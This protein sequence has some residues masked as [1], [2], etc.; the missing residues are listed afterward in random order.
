MMINVTMKDIMVSVVV[1]VVAVRITRTISS[2]P[3]FAAVIPV[4]AEAPA[5]ATNIF[6]RTPAIIGTS[7][8]AVI[9][10]EF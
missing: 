6:L 2:V 1:N 10:A 7:A 9:F 8:S 3:G 5:I 4:V